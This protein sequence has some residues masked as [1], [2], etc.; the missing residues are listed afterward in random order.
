MLFFSSL[1]SQGRNDCMK[2]F[3]P[4]DNLHSDIQSVHKRYFKT[5]I[6]KPVY[7]IWRKSGSQTE[8]GL[9]TTSY[10]T[11]F[12]AVQESDTRL[13]FYSFY[14][15]QVTEAAHG[16]QGIYSLVDISC[17]YF[18]SPKSAVIPSRERRDLSWAA[19]CYWNNLT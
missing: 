17:V 1:R 2:R 14:I 9:P 6:F 18:L 10:F 5:A 15:L 13:A 4:K 7:S 3:Y 8:C 11:I 12:P 19:V 16:L